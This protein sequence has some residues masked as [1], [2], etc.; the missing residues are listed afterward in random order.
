MR[1]DFSKIFLSYGVNYCTDD[2]PLNLMLEHLDFGPDND[3]REMGRYISTELI[4]SAT[5]IDH[6]ARPILKTW[7]LLEGRMD[8]VWLSKD[9]Y[10]I[11]QKLQE[12]GTVR[13]IFSSRNLMYHF[14]SGYLI[15]DSGIFCTLTLTAQTAYA[16]WKYADDGTRESFLPKFLEPDNPWYG[17]T[18]YSE[19]QGGS[20]LGSNSTAAENRN[21]KWEVNGSDKYFASNAGIADGSIV[22]A[23]IA[24]APSGAKGISIFFVPALRRDGK[25]N[26]RIRRLKDKLGTVAVPTGEVELESSE[27]YLLGD[28]KNGIYQALEL[29]TISRIDDALAAVGMARKALWEAYL[30][31]AKR[32]AF[33]KAIIEHPLLKRDFLEME[34]DLEGALI[35]SLLAARNFSL[36]IESRPPYDDTYHYARMLSHIAKNM[37]SETGSEITRYM[38]EVIGGKGFFAE[39]PMEKFHRDAIVTSIWEGTSNIQA[40]DLLEILSRKH[41]HER[42]FSDLFALADVFHDSEL[43]DR[44]LNRIRE[45]RRDVVSLLQSDKP[46]FYGKDII[47]RL[48][49]ITAAVHLTAVAE[50]SGSA[51]LR[52]AA[53]IYSI[54]HV[55]KG[56]VLRPEILARGETLNWMLQR[57]D[58]MKRGNKK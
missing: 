55:E 10:R 6:Y 39:F 51:E 44:I 20:D 52:T 53:E 35:L 16:L 1:F 32:K 24:G 41:T 46:E 18:Y 11:L 57:G 23:R 56:G 54:R 3:M 13:K 43:R 2:L 29:L 28:T 21:G 15:S 50:R 31:A 17:A 22:T 5:Y 19:I 40:L 34:S 14:V 58:N 42:L 25:S 8:G 30:Y 49:H 33:G 48:G 4:E 9:H 12:F 38:L 45:T 36:A 7:D 27:A 47:G 37:A 26:Y